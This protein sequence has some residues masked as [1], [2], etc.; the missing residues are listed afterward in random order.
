MAENEA[1][2]TPIG[3]A[4]VALKANKAMNLTTSCAALRSG[5]AR[6]MKCRISVGPGERLERVAG[7]DEG[8]CEATRIRR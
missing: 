7:A 6:P 1:G 2:I 3:R 5:K 4:T 8:R